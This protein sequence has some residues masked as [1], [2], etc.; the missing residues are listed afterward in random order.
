MVLTYAVDC[1]KMT[2]WLVHFISLAY[3]YTVVINTGKASQQFMCILTHV[4]YDRNI[5]G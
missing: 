3:A 2:A 1:I 4:S 5:Y